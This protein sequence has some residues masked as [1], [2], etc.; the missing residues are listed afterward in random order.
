MRISD[1]SSDVCSSDL[2][3]ALPE[4]ERGEMIDGLKSFLHVNDDESFRM[5]VA[6][7]V[8]SLRPTGPYP[9]LMISGEQ[10]SSKTTTARV[11]RALC[12]PNLAPGRAPPRDE[13]D[14][15]RSAEHTSELQSIIRISYADFCL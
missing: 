6:W 12:D 15:I 4:P 3:R 14:L 9:I 11:C 13:R 5:I 2:M 7:L 10:G 8:A 1:W